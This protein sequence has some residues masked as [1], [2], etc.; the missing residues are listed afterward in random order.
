MD[1]L[2]SNV[3]VTG[4]GEEGGKRERECVWRQPDISDENLETPPPPSGLR[5]K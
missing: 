1:A 2:C 3:E 4:E 5:R